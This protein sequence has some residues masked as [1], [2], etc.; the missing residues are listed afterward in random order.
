MSENNQNLVKFI[1]HLIEKS[2]IYYSESDFSF[3]LYHKNYKITLKGINHQ[4]QIHFEEEKK[5]KSAFMRQE[6]SF[7]IPYSLMEK[8]IA[9]CYDK[10]LEM[11]N[12][13]SFI[14]ENNII[15][16]LYKELQMNDFSKIYK[17]FNTQFN[18]DYDENHENLN[19]I[20]LIIHQ[21][22]LKHTLFLGSSFNHNYTKRSYSLTSFFKLYVET[23][24]NNKQ[25]HFEFHIPGQE[26]FQ[27]PLFRKILCFENIH[28]SSDFFEDFILNKTHDQELYKFYLDSTLQQ[29]SKKTLQYKL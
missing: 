10:I 2:D 17:S 24:I 29:D 16:F 6:T 8:S 7:L 3:Y 5:S 15:P 1:H 26:L 27:M 22:K 9:I 23:V 14:Q 13:N 20:E 18:D 19:R 28:N 4:I 25:E 11:K 21:E 12:Y